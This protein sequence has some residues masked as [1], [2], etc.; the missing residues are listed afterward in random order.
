MGLPASCRTTAWVRP[1]VVTAV[2]ADPTF[3]NLTETAET[4]ASWI[5]ASL[6][7]PPALGT[8]FVAKW[9]GGPRGRRRLGRGEKWIGVVVLLRLVCQR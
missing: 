7:M 2:V 5:E 8:A 6:Q 4:E 3:G 1:E 9:V